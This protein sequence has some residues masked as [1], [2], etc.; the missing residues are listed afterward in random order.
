MHRRNAIRINPMRCHLCVLIVGTTANT[1]I[2]R[3]VI[4]LKISKQ[5]KSLLFFNFYVEGFLLERFFSTEFV[6]RVSPVFS[7]AIIL[8]F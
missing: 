5:E 8:L 1:D 2:F 6:R 4:P 7:E 3:I